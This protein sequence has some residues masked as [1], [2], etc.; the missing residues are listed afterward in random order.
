[1]A[2][3]RAVVHAFRAPIGSFLL[4][5]ASRRRPVIDQ[6]FSHWLLLLIACHCSLLLFI[7]SLLYIW[8]SRLS[9]G[10]LT[11]GAF[12]PGCHYHHPFVPPLGA[13]VAHAFIDIYDIPALISCLFLCL[14]VSGQMITGLTRCSYL[15]SLGYELGALHF[16]ASPR[17]SPSN[18]SR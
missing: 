15:S 4:L 18:T 1:M 3:G 17:E 8:L 14:G 16:G 2:Q 6:A 11:W 5:P 10:S 13:P 7:A 9:Q 12:P